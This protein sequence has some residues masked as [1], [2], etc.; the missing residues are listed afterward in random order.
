MI[1]TELALDLLPYVIGIYEKLDL[2]AVGARILQ[3][4]KKENPHLTAGD[5]NAAVGEKVIVYVIKNVPKVKDELFAMVA[6]VS[7]IS[8]DDAK[9]QSL[10][11]TMDAFKKIFSDPELLAFF[12]EA[13]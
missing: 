9:A 4:V 7:G 5:I 3:Q 11:K 1:K 12:K 10:V 8:L 13:M 6:L 2:K